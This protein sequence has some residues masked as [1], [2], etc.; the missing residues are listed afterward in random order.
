LCL[1]INGGTLVLSAVTVNKL[2]DHNC[3]ITLTALNTNVP[4]LIDKHNQA[5]G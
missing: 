2:V 1:S 3:Q 4:P 5:K